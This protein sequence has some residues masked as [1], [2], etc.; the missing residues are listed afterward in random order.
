MTERSNSQQS[1]TQDSDY[2][3]MPTLSRG[4]AVSNQWHDCHAEQPQQRGLAQ[5]LRDTDGAKV[6]P[7][8]DQV[9]FY[10][11]S[12]HQMVPQSTHPIKWACYSFIDLLV[13]SLHIVAS[14]KLF[15][16]CGINDVGD[17]TMMN[18]LLFLPRTTSATSALVC[19]L[20]W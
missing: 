4:T 17:V 8:S 19:L 7:T 2:I 15:L 6:L 14:V 16:L 10:L 20:Y 12:T 5:K 11:A 13:H 1:V 18:W 3:S 9:G